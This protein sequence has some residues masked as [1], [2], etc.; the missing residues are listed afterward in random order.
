MLSKISIISNGLLV[1]QIRQLI[2]GATAE[3]VALA[4]VSIL[5]NDAETIGSLHQDLDDPIL[6]I[7]ETTGSARLAAYVQKDWP[8]G[9][10]VIVVEVVA[11]LERSIC[12]RRVDG[13]VGEVIDGLI[14]DMRCVVL[15]I[16][17]PHYAVTIR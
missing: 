10:V 7:L 6:Q 14:N 4:V 13:V 1:R 16:L 3:G 12:V 17:S 8:A 2:S 5:K 9:L 11:L 15:W